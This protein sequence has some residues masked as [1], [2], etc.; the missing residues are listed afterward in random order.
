M[1]EIQANPVF[2]K[3]Y[4]G[5]E[6]AWIWSDWVQFE[7]AQVE[8]DLAS[9]GIHNGYITGAYSLGIPAILFFVIALF[10]QI[11]SSFKRS[12]SLLTTDPVLSDLHSVIFANLIGIVPS[13]YIGTD[14]N[15]PTI[16][17]YLALGIL[18]TRSARRE[19]TSLEHAPSPELVVR[20]VPA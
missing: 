11:F 14:L 2:G 19:A 6:N 12:Q 3:G 17:L 16:W 8:V 5:L 1:E 10:A 13:I 4:G 9:G 15:G 7:Q 18:L 20:T